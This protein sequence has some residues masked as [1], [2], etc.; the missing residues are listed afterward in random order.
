[1]FQPNSVIYF[2]DAYTPNE[3]EPEL[4]LEYGV[5]R[6][7]REQ[8]DRPEVYVHTY[9]RPETSIHRV[10]WPNAQ[11]YMKIDRDFIEGNLNLPTLND[12]IEEDYLNGKTVVC[13]DASVE[14]LY[15]LTGN[16]LNIQSIL[17]MWN[18]CILMMRMP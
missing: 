16:S 5:L 11:S 10:R 6:W 13:V 2:V 4:S 15:N 18:T 12:M 1:M 8:S 7:N 17:Y 9:L 3:G 14:P